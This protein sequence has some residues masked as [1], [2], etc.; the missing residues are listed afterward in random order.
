MPLILP[1]VLALHVGSALY[2]SIVRLQ[3]AL[4][5]AILKNDLIHL[6]KDFIFFYLI[7][8]STRD[9]YILSILHIIE[10]LKRN[11]TSAS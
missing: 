8:F 4:Y 10:V 6:R 1:P 2:W 3:I 11:Y 7:F 9:V 5:L